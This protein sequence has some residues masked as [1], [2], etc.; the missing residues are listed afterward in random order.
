M[1]ISQVAVYVRNGMAEHY[2][3]PA[4]SSQ[5]LVEAGDEPSGYPLWTV[6][7]NDPNRL[8]ALA[9]R[10]VGLAYVTEAYKESG[11]LDPADVRLELLNEAGVA[12]AT[13]IGTDSE[14][15]KRWHAAEIARQADQS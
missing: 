13:A 2:P 4:A 3:H 5:T 7:V 11:V 8:P 1:I 15:A 14:R 10:L 9:A 6:T 12:V